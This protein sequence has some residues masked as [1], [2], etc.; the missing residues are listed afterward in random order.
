[1]QRSGLGHSSLERSGL[2]QNSGSGADTLLLGSLASVSGAVARSTEIRE[3]GEP[4][5][6]LEPGSCIAPDLDDREHI[7][8]SLETL[9]TGEPET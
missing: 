4:M 8:D 6:H 5:G 2:I 1:M 9:C 7:G 3:L